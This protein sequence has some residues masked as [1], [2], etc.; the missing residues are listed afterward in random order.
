[1]AVLGIE[2]GAKVGWVY[3][4]NEEEARASVPEVKRRAQEA[5]ARGYDFGYQ[6]P[7]NVERVAGGYKGTLPAWRVV[8][9]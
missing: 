5:A 3:Y 8:T 7:G 1:M 2:S 4:D 9:S 6:F